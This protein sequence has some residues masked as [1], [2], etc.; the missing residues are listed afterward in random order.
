MR[1]TFTIALLT[2]ALLV[3]FTTPAAASFGG[4]A[5]ANLSPA[6]CGGGTP[7]I[8]VFEPVRNDVDSGSFG[9]WAF[10][11]YVRNITVW[12]TAANTYCAIVGYAGSFTTIAGN[13]PGSATVQIPAGIRGVMYGGY[14]ATFTATGRVSSP[15]WP[16]YGSTAVVDYGCNAAG[17]CPG[18][19]TWT[20][21][22]F[23]G[24][25]AFETPWW[26]WEYRAGRHGTW[27]NVITGNSGNIV[28]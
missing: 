20:E 4:D 25:D 14:R 16:T 26:G 2:V 10:D 23:G 15:G 9:N 28:P 1:R 5:A 12:Q 19:I 11:N 6:R 27:A 3:A 7:V 18:R 17:F 8:S 24:V 21:Q 22:Y 13:S